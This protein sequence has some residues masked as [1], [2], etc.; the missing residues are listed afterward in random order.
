MSTER[1]VCIRWATSSDNAGRV[2]MNPLKIEEEIRT[3]EAGG[4]Q[5]EHVFCNHYPDEYG[6]WCM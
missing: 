4:W 3:Q 5:L 6:I 1:K 2:T